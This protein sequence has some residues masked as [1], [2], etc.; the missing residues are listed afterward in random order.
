MS[1]LEA[2]ERHKPAAQNETAPSATTANAT[3]Q[4]T[5][6]PPPA[7]GTESQ[8]ASQDEEDKDGGDGDANEGD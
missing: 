8:T 4:A 5:N 6:S 1:S 7:S 3:G 2:G